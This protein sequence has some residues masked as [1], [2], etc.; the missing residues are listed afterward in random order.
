MMRKA[1][2]PRSS[3]DVGYGDSLTVNGGAQLGVQNGYENGPSISNGSTRK[4]SVRDPSGAIIL[5]GYKHE[6]LNGFEG[7]P[8]FNPVSIVLLK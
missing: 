7:K 3:Q 5:D 8:R 6:I 1:L 4:P 2:L